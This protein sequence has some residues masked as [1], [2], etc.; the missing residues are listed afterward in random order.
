MAM[1]LALVVAM[2]GISG[3]AGDNPERIP[4][5]EMSTRRPLSDVLNDNAS[6]LM[7]I[8]S[9]VGVY[10]GVMGDGEACIVI[11]AKADRPGLR[12]DIPDTL[13][14]HRVRV[15]ITGEI[16]PLR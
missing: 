10:E 14:G 1:V 15:E 16:R 9:V 7:G 11:M 12:R 5:A 3:C 13:E 2:A 8:E 4:A 6:R